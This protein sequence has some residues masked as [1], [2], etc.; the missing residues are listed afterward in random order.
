MKKMSILYITRKAV[1]QRAGRRAALAVTYRAGH[2]TFPQKNAYDNAP[3][4]ALMSAG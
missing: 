4:T 1:R 3:C 2:P